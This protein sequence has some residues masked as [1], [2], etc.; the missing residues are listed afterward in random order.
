MKK[1]IKQKTSSKNNIFSSLAKVLK[2]AKGYYLHLITAIIAVTIGVVLELLGP[3]ELSKI[4]N[5][6]K[7]GFINGI[8]ISAV[9]SIAIF[10]VIIYVIMGIM[11]L[12]EGML[13]AHVTQKV[14]KR[15]RTNISNKINNLPL[16]TLDKST[17]GDI[18]SRITNDADTIGQALNNSTSGVVASIVL[19]C[20]SVIMMFVHSWIMALSGIAA[21]IIGFAL[22]SIILKKSQK[23]FNARQQRLGL[24]NGHIEEA[25][26]NH[27]TIVVCNAKSQEFNKFN[28]L[29]KDLF[30]SDF[31]SQ[32]LSG[33]M[34]PLMGFV[35]NLGF[36]VVCI[37][38]AVLVINGMIEIGTIV[39][40]MIYIRYFTQPLTQIAQSLTSLQS[41]AAASTR[42][43]DFLNQE[44]LTDE[45]DKTTKLTN[46]K[47]EVE[48]KDIKFSY[49]NEKTI[50]K[51]FSVK[52]PA[53]SKVAIVG[54]T[55]AGKTTLVNLLMRFY[56]SQEGDIIVD[57]VSIYDITR[58][59]VHDLYS[60]VLQ[61]TWLFEGTIEENLVF[62]KK[63]I[64]HSV[65]E[66]ACKECD[67]HSFITSLPD[68]YN[69]VLKDDT[70][71][72]AGQKQLLTIAR[73]MIQNAPLLILDEATSNVDTRTELKLQ[74][75]MD[76]L[77]T[78][79]TSFV[80]AHRL[81]TIKNSDII[82]VMKEGDIIESGSHNELLELNGF[83]A[84]LYKSQFDTLSDED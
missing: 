67:I 81:S 64:P 44:E 36:V 75:A 8:D 24:L 66:K 57:G 29:N 84:E 5:L 17:K 43:F 30:D 19:F 48:F 25:F 27:N 9:T 22:V 11:Y 79:R 23:H 1:S 12:I 20:G 51:N 39:A 76:K 3:N 50:I 14:T 28:K 70:S 4:T 53:G 72:S 32:F 62:N 18:L 68:G 78:N 42:I 80:I 34:H 33:I 58:E 71:I 55:G 38:G 26:T 10:L 69:T 83:Y 35:G 45:S 56:D 65:I 31:K 37:V 7:E 21:S 15:L 74:Q 60:M 16:K 49:D 63:G 13:V 54:P 46:V 6:I 47:G 40:F 41:A 82:L 2:Y 52:I 77:S 73:A 61:D 59:Q